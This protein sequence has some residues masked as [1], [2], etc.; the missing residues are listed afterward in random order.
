[1][2][3]TRALSRNVAVMWLVLNVASKDGS[4]IDCLSHHCCKNKNDSLTAKPM[5]T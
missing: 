5:N 1:M 3:F 2:W 4:S